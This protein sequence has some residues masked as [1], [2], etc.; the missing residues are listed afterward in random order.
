MSKRKKK[1]RKNT[2]RRKIAG[3]VGTVVDAAQTS[4]EPHTSSHLPDV[5][6]VD[7]LFTVGECEIIKNYSS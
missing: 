3:G 7:D 1:P 6:Y 2:I 4:F 5:I